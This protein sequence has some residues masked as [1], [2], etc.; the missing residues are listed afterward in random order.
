MTEMIGDG[1]TMK[2]STLFSLA[3]LLLAGGTSASAQVPK[4]NGLVQV[5]YSQMLDSNL[6][7]NS[8]SVAPNSYYSM[9]AAFK[10]NG[11]SIRRTEF[12]LSSDIVDGV[13]Y[14]FVFDPSITDGK[15]LQDGLIK[16][17]A[18][19]GIEIKLGQFRDQQTYEAITTPTAELLLAERSMLARVFGDVRDRGVTITV[20]FGSK[21][22]G[23]RAT[24]GVFN[25]AGKNTNDLNAQKDLVYRL[26]LNAGTDHKF[27]FYGLQG[28]TDKPDNGTLTGGT[29][30]GP[31]GAVPTAAAVLGNK[32]K[33]SQIG[34][35]YAYQTSSF[36]FSVDAISGQLGRRFPSLGGAPK[37]EHLDQKFLG[38]VLTGG[39]TTGNHSFL[40]RYDFLN[41]NQGNDWYTTSSPYISGVADYTPKFNEVTAGYT[42]AFNPKSIKA[43]NIKINYIARSKNFLKPR[44][45][46]TGEQGGDTLVAAF[47]IAF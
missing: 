2:R 40:L 32:D 25:G 5:W 34:A 37:R 4:I 17:K 14:E 24:V 18:P 16:Y 3:T 41:Y 45:T 33:T 10:E 9:P 7:A 31:A 21:D 42:Y 19:G 46:Q 29:F 20:P 13:S 15:I 47:Q 12:K 28:S 38:Y 30:A 1:E 22:F 43:A 44:G 11:F 27:G 26:D 23:A 39:Y 8:Y 36:H 6:R 35:Y